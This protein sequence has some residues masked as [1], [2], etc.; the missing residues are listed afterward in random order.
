MALIRSAVMSSISDHCSRSLAKWLC[1]LIL[2]IRW[3]HGISW[4]SYE[5][6]W[7]VIVVIWNDTWGRALDKLEFFRSPGGQSDFI[8]MLMVTA[9]SPAMGQP[10]RIVCIVVL[11]R[12]DET[13]KEVRTCPKSLSWLE[14]EQMS[15][16]SPD[17]YPRVLFT[18]LQCSI[19]LQLLF[20]FKAKLIR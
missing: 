12:T 18:L 13:K 6:T 11:N 20:Q 19:D 10:Y 8:V 5:M 16:G 15:C 17:F 3:D 1:S 4:S 14:A 7:I 9:T 2:F